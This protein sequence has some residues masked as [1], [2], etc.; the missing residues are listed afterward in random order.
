MIDEIC[1]ELVAYH[2]AVFEAVTT[3][4]NDACVRY[5]PENKYLYFAYYRTNAD[6]GDFYTCGTIGISLTVATGWVA[7]THL[8]SGT[9]AVIHGVLYDNCA[10]HDSNLGGLYSNYITYLDKLYDHK[11]YVDQYG[12]HWNVYN[13]FS[14]FNSSGFYMNI[15]F[16]PTAHKEFD[17]A[18]SS[19]FAY[20]YSS[21]EVYN[22]NTKYDMHFPVYVN[23][24]RLYYTTAYM[25]A[26]KS[27]GNNKIYFDFPRFCNDPASYLT[28]IAQ[29]KRFFTINKTNGNLVVNDIISWLDPDNV[30]VHKF[31]VIEVSSAEG[32]RSE[33]FAMP[34]ENAY[35]YS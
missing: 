8:P 28:P 18:N 31:L 16:I 12:I 14:D 30:T 32:A 29:T 4:G 20:C 10:Q 21:R 1:S 25:S 34:Y 23:Q 7:G 11:L 17:D 33:Y 6:I 2:P 3:T 22:N 5:I 24:S 15:E 9:T 27:L 26:F 35:Q 13:P 19:I